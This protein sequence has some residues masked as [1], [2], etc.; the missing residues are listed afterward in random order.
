ML[1]EKEEGVEFARSSIPEQ[2]LP[3]HPAVG[4][5]R[6]RGSGCMGSQ[7]CT[8]AYPLPPGSE[9]VL[10]EAMLWF[11]ASKSCDGGVNLRKEAREPL[12]GLESR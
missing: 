12:P 8:Q 10:E 1:P 9:Q 7:V 4:R 2:G 11:P 5:K 3:P 6:V